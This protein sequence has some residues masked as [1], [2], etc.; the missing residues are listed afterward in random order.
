[1][2]KNINLD[3]TLLYLWLGIKGFLWIILMSYLLFKITKFNIIKYIFKLISIIFQFMGIL[4]IISLIH[5]N[6]IENPNSYIYILFTL[7]GISLIIINII[8]LKKMRF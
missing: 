2:I 7:I 5:L 8:K 1:M 4:Y 6:Q 3:I